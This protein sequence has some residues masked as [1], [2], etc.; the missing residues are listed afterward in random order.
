[1]WTTD[2]KT[3]KK[4]VSLTFALIA[5]IVT[6]LGYIAS[7]AA[8]FFGLA[9]PFDVGA[10]GVYFTSTLALYFS[11]KHTESQES[12]HKDSIIAQSRVTLESN[13]GE[14]GDK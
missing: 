10:A 1:M 11:R 4:S 8:G 9:V 13:P 7:F 14:E 2:P 6:S 5:F 12:K 3:K